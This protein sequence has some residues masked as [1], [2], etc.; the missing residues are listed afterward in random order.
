LA[1]IEALEVKN[2]ALEAK[3]ENLEQR[4]N[5]H[6]RR[7]EDVEFASD[8]CAPALRTEFLKN[9]T[10]GEFILDANKEKIVERRACVFPP[11]GRYEFIDNLVRFDGPVDFNN[12][13]TFDDN[14]R[15]SCRCPALKISRD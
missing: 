14:V 9:A 2:A 3:V 12:D 11:I 4:Q 10:T 1:R 7:L 6:R 13:V 8:E 5:S 15:E